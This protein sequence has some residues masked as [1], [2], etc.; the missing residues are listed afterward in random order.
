ML[1]QS[2]FEIE[3]G[4]VSLYFIDFHIPIKQK[5]DKI[6]IEIGRKHSSTHPYLSLL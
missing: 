5:P 2:F 3:I 4:M 1:C 6:I